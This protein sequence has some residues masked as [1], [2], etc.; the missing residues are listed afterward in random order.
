MNTQFAVQRIERRYNMRTTAM[1]V[2][3]HGRLGVDKVITENLS[4]RGVRVLS[5]CEWMLDDTILVSIPAAHFTS[6]ARVAYC[7]PLG[8]GRFGTGLEFIGANEP[9][10]V[11]TL[12]AA[13]PYP[14][15]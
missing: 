6:A 15:P 9:L 1:L 14:R 11:N 12:A 5:Q 4:P 2:G 8:D 13:Q 7:A 10:Q 3:T